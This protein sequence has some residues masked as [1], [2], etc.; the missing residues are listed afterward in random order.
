MNLNDKRNFVFS[1]IK[2]FSFTSTLASDDIDFDNKHIRDVLVKLN[3]V[4]ELF[5]LSIRI[6]IKSIECVDKRL[7]P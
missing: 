6:L 3:G 4:Q 7:I 1:E 5:L 2:I